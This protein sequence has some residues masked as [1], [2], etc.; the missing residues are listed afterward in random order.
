MIG[1]LE[2]HQQRNHIVCDSMLTDCLAKVVKRNF[3]DTEAEILYGKENLIKE[4][5]LAFDYKRIR[6]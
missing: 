2:D 3:D 6:L 5:L 1:I 4:E